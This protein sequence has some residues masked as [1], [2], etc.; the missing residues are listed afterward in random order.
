MAC[1]V[2]DKMAL[3]YGEHLSLSSN[4][5]LGFYAIVDLWC[6]KCDVRLVSKEAMVSFCLRSLAYPHSHLARKDISIL[7][8]LNTLKFL[9]LLVNILLVLKNVWFS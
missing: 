6:F 4:G 7:R 9:Q 2:H 1:S 8:K 3:K 5:I